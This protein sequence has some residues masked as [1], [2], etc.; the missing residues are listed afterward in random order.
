MPVARALGRMI[1]QELVPFGYSNRYIMRAVRAQGYGYRTSLLNNDINLF[2]GRAQHQYH[3]GK[4]ND[5]DVVPDYLM[6]P[7]ELGQPYKYRV[8]FKSNY[9][10]LESDSYVTVDESMYTNDYAKIGDWKEANEL[11]TKSRYEEAGM[12]FVNSNVVSVDL[13][14]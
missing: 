11:R 2:A 13:Q 4:L 6:A 14:Q 1:I 3:I 7:G 10:D 12:E 8:R 5:N 9:Y